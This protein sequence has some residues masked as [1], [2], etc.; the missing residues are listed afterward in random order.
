MNYKHIIFDFG[1][2]LATFQSDDLL[3]SYCNSEDLPILKDAIYHNWQALD[4]GS[5]SYEKYQEETLHLLPD[6][7]HD[8]AR[9]CFAT[10]YQHMIP[11]QPVWDM[12]HRLKEQQTGL[13]IL[14]NAPIFF[15]EHADFFEITRLFDGAVYSGSIKKF[16]PHRLKEQQTGLYIL[17]NAPIF[18][19][20]HADF[21]EI[22]R[23]FDG[24]VYSGSIKKFKP[25]PDIYQ[26]LFDT[27]S[28]DPSDCFFMD[29]KPENI[30]AA[31]KLGMN[32]MVFTGENLSE[33][34]H[35]IGLEE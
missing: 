1:N 22:T 19:E 6:C 26:H 29:D 20:E 31:Q 25:N 24:A 28:L 11:I 16:K 18:F 13:Y 9:K 3:R 17:S 15:E 35:A 4:E 12:I 21:F 14:S 2:V 7:L 5:I 33:I 32:G 27:F 23:L 8:T 34:K 10:W 30:K